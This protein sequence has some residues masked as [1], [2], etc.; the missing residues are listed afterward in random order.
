[1]K[2]KKLAILQIILA[3]IIIIAELEMHNFFRLFSWRS[4]FIIFNPMIITAILMILLGIKFIKS[5]Q[6]IN[7][8][9]EA[10][11][12]KIG[13]KKLPN[14]TAGIII[15][16]IGII[17]FIFPIYLAGLFTTFSISRLGA[18]FFDDSKIPFTVLSIFL[19]IFGVYIIAKNKKPR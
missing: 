1:M 5:N 14:K 11:F 2:L 19:I 10:L 13:L 17:V 15:L 6:E 8:H 12:S 7:F 9:L 4:I 18:L 3:V 16:I